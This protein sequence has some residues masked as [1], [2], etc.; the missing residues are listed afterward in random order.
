MIQKD[1]IISTEK[2]PNNETSKENEVNDFEVLIGDTYIREPFK[3]LEQMETTTFNNNSSAGPDKKQLRKPRKRIQLQARKIP[4]CS[5]LDCRCN[6]AKQ[7]KILENIHKYKDEHGK[8]QSQLKE[9][10]S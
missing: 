3:W 9:A 10:D 5:K 6:C 2:I 8:A 4:A 1:R 7:T